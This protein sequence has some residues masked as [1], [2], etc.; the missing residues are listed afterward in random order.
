VRPFNGAIPRWWAARVHVTFRAEAT[1]RLLRGSRDR[2]RLRGRRADSVDAQM[3]M[4]K[5]VWPQSSALGLSPSLRSPDDACQPRPCSGAVAHCPVTPRVISSLSAQSAWPRG[6]VQWRWSLR[7]LEDGAGRF[8]RIRLIRQRLLC[9][10][11]RSYQPPTL[12]VIRCSPLQTAFLPIFQRWRSRLALRERLPSV[13]SAP[14][15]SH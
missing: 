10:K 4:G 9:C 15:A 3:R 14:S 6:R 7:L 5:T 1:V 13:V 8:C 2:R 12:R 11:N